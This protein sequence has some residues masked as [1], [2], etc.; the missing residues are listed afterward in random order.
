[1][2][3]DIE[4]GGIRYCQH[5]LPARPHTVGTTDTSQESKKSLI[6]QARR[7]R[8]GEAFSTTADQTSRTRARQAWIARAVEHGSQT[9]QAGAGA[10]LTAL[11]A[12]RV[13]VGLTVNGGLPKFLKK[14]EIDD[15]PQGALVD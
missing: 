10:Q 7:S 1:M 2:Q 4:A 8:I 12:T 5:A 13:H 14:A 9:R 15:Q 3:H 11:R 6:N